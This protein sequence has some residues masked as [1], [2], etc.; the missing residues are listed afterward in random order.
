M[1]LYGRNLSPFVRRVAIWMALQG[2]DVTRRELSV[3]DDFEAVRA[4]NPVARVPALELDDGRVLIE[5]WAICDYLEMTAPD[6]RTLVPKAGDA[7]VET[8]RRIALASGA[9]DK[10]VALVYETTRRPEQFHFP[11]WRARLETQVGGGLAA[12]EDLT[13]ATGWLGGASPDGADIAF[14]CAWDMAAAVTPHM[15]AAG[16]PRLR[17]LSARANALPAFAGSR[18]A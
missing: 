2:R 7:R 10:I 4:L 1:I 16:H 14:V 5:T 15:A 8:L 9:A 3:A 11:A 12:L 18:P 6:G 17:A 13:P